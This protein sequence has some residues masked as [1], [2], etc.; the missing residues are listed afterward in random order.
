MTASLGDLAV[1]ETCAVYNDLSHMNPRYLT[2]RSY[3]STYHDEE[4]LYHKRN[5]ILLSLYFDRILICTDNISA[6]TR[7]MTKDVVSSVVISKWF[8]DLVESGIIVIAGWGSSLNS[9]M[10]A[11][12]IDYSKTYR[13]ELK[14]ET[15]S[16][17]LFGLSEKA[18]WVI[19]EP[20]PGEAEHVNFLR[21]LVRRQEGLLEVAEVSFLA[22]LIDHTHESVGYVGTM[23]IFPYIDELFAGQQR[24]A[25][26]F[27]RSYY[28]SWHAYCA[29]HYAPAVP[30]HTDRISL[31]TT[32]VELSGSGRRALSSLFSPALF[33]RYLLSRF[34]KSIVNRILAV[35]VSE[36]LAIRNGDWARFRTR[37]HEHLVAASAVCW[38][39]YHPRAH[40]LVSDDELMDE[41]LSEIFNSSR[42]DT[43][44]SGLGSALD[45]AIGLF[46]GIPVMTPIFQVFKRQINRR[47]GQLT[48]SIGNREFEPY[49]KK[50]GRVLERPQEL[51]IRP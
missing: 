2:A 34:D 15:Y 43:D 20:G 30:I 7:F 1:R 22:D 44:L 50:L 16:N 12:Q 11:N 40:E 23:E 9:D 35:N 48:R 33:Q 5:L 6:F 41:L 24:K 38:I 51:A 49:L 32:W 45:V 19:R 27:F 39:A 14:D 4:V 36:L 18:Q 3:G 13:P 46:A 21:P 37:Y 25:D 17:T 29:Q 42:H 26:S 47:F 10:M 8:N 28:T 31:P